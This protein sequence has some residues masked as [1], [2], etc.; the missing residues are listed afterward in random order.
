MASPIRLES[1]TLG[2]VLRD[3]AEGDLADISALLA[4]PRVHDSLG[5]GSV[6]STHQQAAEYVERHADARWEPNRTDFVFAVTTA[7]QSAVE[8]TPGGIR[9]N[10]VGLVE[11]APGSDGG[12]AEIGF[13]IHVDY[14]RQGISRAAGAAVLK[15][16][17]ETLALPT[18]V[19]KC[20]LTNTG[21]IALLL[22]LGMQ[23][24][25][26]R[27]EPGDDDRPRPYAR[28]QIWPLDPSE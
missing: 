22:K 19:A 16:A 24:M 6:P 28:F 14:W 3:V 27:E 13:L 20:V 25:D 11:L 10:V 7:P 12:D 21:S 17:F 18:V 5:A 8:P 2:L 15:F 23:R 4:D 1:E 26:D 9:R